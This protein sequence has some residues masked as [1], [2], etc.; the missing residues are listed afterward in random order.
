MKRYFFGLIFFLIT[1]SIYSQCPDCEPDLTCTSDLG[2]WM[3]PE[4]VP[5]GVAN[6]YYEEVLTF[7][8]PHEF[9]DPETGAAVTLNSVIITNVV[10]I[11]FGMEVTFNNEDLTYNPSEG[12]E[13]GCATL[14]GTPLLPGVY[15][16][17]ISI[18]AFA[19]AFG[20]DVEIDEQFLL[21]L[22]VYEGEGTNNSFS[23]DLLT[24]CDQADINFAGTINGDPQPTTWE[25]DFGNG[26][27][28]DEQFPPIQTYEGA[29]EYDVSLTTKLYNLEIT[30]VQL[31][32]LS[33]GWAGDVEEL[34][35]GI[36]NPDPYFTIADADGNVIY[37][38]T[39]VTNTT[40]TT[41]SGLSIIITD[42]PYSISFYDE[43]AISADDFLGTYIIGDE[44][45]DQSF[46]V[47][48]GTTGIVFVDLEVDLEFNNQETVTIFETTPADFS[49]DLENEIIFFEN[50]DLVGFNWFLD[51]V[52]IPDANEPSLEMTQF[53]SY[54]CDVLNVWGCPSSS[55]IYMFCPDISLTFNDE[56]LGA[57]FGPY[58]YVWYVNGEIIEGEITNLLSVE[59]SGNYSVQILTESGCDIISEIFS[60]DGISEYI[61]QSQFEVFPNPNDGMFTLQDK[62]MS[63][64]GLM[65][66]ELF[67]LQGKLVFDDT[68][69]F[70][71][72]HDIDLQ[73][74]E[75]HGVYLIK[76]Y[77]QNSISVKRL[78]IN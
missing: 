67:D 36:S 6:V 12:E 37:T 13:H 4:I 70:N 46:N 44:D 26:N 15:D 64:D 11:P 16:G 23:F 31:N 62:N 71:S 61:N 8:M 50:P 24:G 5:D 76:I 22:V 47:N 29:G 38:S 59:E 72:S 60:Y 32:D 49:V 34:F 14:C 58:T 20:I 39:S 10:G 65:K 7:Y 63:S 1:I 68:F 42:G 45:G 43:D 57:P 48:S 35:E 28:S 40:S 52:E 75:I 9:N 53:G 33:S 2:P 78:M 54:Q 77:F 66:I 17:V 74:K 19:S 56:T 69:I 3:C 27:T 25:W 21:T 73:N 41:W 55:E 18:H 30:S 51:G